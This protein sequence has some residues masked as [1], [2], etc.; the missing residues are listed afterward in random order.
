[1]RSK[2][3]SFLLRDP[4]EAQFLDLPRILLY[5]KTRSFFDVRLGNETLA[6]HLMCVRASYDLRMRFCEG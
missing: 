2:D 5:P 4:F 1:M 3:G 6:R